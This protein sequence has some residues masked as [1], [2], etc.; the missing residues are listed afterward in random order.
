MSKTPP[1][2]ELDSV[3][4]RF[5]R[6]PVVLESLQTRVRPGEF[7]SLVGPSG[8]GKSTFLRLIAG[9]THPS[10]GKV[11]F[12]WPDNGDRQPVNPELAFIFQDSTLL[13]WLSVAGNIATPMRLRGLRSADRSAT[14]HKMARLVGLEDVLDF[15]PRQLSGGMRMRV[16]LARALSL[17]PHILLLDEPFGALDAITRNRL[18]EELLAIRDRE[19]WT[20]FFV[21]HSVNEAVFLSHRVWILSPIPGR[22]THEIDIDLPFPRTQETRESRAFQ[23]YVVETAARLREV[24]PS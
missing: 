4:K 9:L 8:C 6:G 12:R 19:Q 14:V 10:S 2:I 18:N 21:T 16:S 1:S 23:D 24:L 11:H 17:S 15:Y 7:V 13:P 20:A 5:D 22:I 3:H